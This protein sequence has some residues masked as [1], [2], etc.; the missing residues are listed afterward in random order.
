MFFSKLD[1]SRIVFSN[2]L[3]LMAFV[4][5]ARIVVK[6]GNGG[7]GCESHY[8]D[9]WMRYPRPDG[10]NGGDGGSVIFVADPHIQTLLDFRF[11]QHY[12]AKKGNIGSSKGST[13]RCGEDCVLRVPLGTVIWDDATGLL[14]R[15][16]S[17]PGDRVVVAQGGRAGIGNMHRKFAV[18]PEIGVQREIRLELKVIAD[19][20]LVGFPNA[21]KST[22]ISSVSKVRSKVA[23][24]PFTTKQP[25]L[26]IVETDE[27]SFVMADL[28]GL[29][30]GAHLGKGLGYQFLKH[31]ERTNIL[32]QV[33][34]MAGAE[35]RDPLKDYETILSELEQYSDL[36]AHKHRIVV[37]NK[38]DLPEAKR[39]LKRF[40]RKYKNIQV[41]P[42]SALDKKGLETLVDEIIVIL[43]QFAAHR[44]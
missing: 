2:S 24:Y 13:G 20:G 44:I 36:L 18:P 27:V 32:V 39:H 35:E 15:D 4:D 17:T 40:K 9:L 19:V 33:I 22:L 16:L 11:K 31:A 38:M 34:D 26:G 28:P 14:I 25:V 7:K 41:F 21:G 23:N 1:M 42:V 12:Q 43:K 3:N 29:I 5:S 37:A 6:A 30:E 8:R 10:G